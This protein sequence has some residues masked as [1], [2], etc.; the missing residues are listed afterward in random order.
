MTVDYQN[1]AGFDVSDNQQENKSMNIVVGKGQDEEI[2]GNDKMPVGAQGSNKW[3]LLSFVTKKSPT[4]YNMLYFRT[5]NLAL[6]EEN[7]NNDYIAPIFRDYLMPVSSWFGKKLPS[8]LKATRKLIEHPK[9]GTP[10]VVNFVDVRTQWFD[11]HVQ[12]AATDGITQ[13][14]ILAAGFDTRAYRFGNR[15][16]ITFYEIDL[17]HAS[18][19]KQAMVNKLLSADRFPR[20]EY[21]AADLSKASLEDALESTSFDPTQRTLFT[22]EG[23]IYYLPEEAVKN[24]FLGLEAVAA[25]GSRIFFDFLHKGCL[26][27]TINP[28]GWMTTALSVANKGEPFLSGFRPNFLWLRKY[29]KPLG[30]RLFE[31][32]NPKEMMQIFK[33]HIRWN[34]EL[35]PMLSFY[36]FAGIQKVSNSPSNNSSPVSSP[37]MS[38]NNSLSMDQYPGLKLQRSQFGYIDDI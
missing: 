36:S 23:L 19:K 1:A 17:P 24:L 37:A 34:D 6:G 28:P 11:S 3:G 18:K 15:K 4:N 8:S 12:Q 5:L 7:S 32:K 13:V 25:P 35:P 10:G 22:I 30:F 38:P 33:P 31:Q 21:V 20:P 29:F 27:G 14:V 16:G 2:T 26:E 9:K